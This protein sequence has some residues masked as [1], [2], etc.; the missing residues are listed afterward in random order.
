MA[1]LQVRSPTGPVATMWSHHEK[2]LEWHGTEVPSYDLALN[3]LGRIDLGL[4]QLHKVH[5][6]LFELV[7]G[8]LQRGDAR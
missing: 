2:L 4:S 1:A 6:L 5:R 8:I 7:A 3:V